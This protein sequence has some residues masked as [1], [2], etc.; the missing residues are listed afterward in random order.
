[1]RPDRRR[2]AVH[3][4]AAAALTLSALASQADVPREVHGRSDAYAGHGIAI[5]WAT[6]RGQTEDATTIVV[7]I[8]ADRTRYDRVAI[9]G[10]DPFGGP[11]QVR[12]PLSPLAPG[13]QHTDIRVQR[14]RFADAPRSEMKFFSPDAGDARVVVFY[15]GVPDTTPEFVDPAKLDAF[16]TERIR[17]LA[18]KAGQP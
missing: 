8:T 12:A 4:L 13:G 18:R 3:G 9:D 10:V 6:L 5:A 1:M 2:I 17:D 7:R 11:R 15:D 16:L 14:S